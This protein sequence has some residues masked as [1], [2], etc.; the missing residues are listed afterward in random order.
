[1]WQ[2]K[3]LPDY[4]HRYTVRANYLTYPCTSLADAKKLARQLLGAKR[5]YSTHVFSTGT[6]G[7]LSGRLY[8]GTPTALAADGD[9]TAGVQIDTLNGRL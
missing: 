5:L 9:G 4:S 7:Q 2:P 1:M 3:Y 6:T 8:Y